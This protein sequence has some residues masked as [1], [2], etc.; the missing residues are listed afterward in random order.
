M[1]CSAVEKH[2]VWSSDNTPN[3]LHTARSALSCPGPF[4][5]ARVAMRRNVSGRISGAPHTLADRAPCLPYIG[6]TSPK[7]V[8][9]ARW[10]HSKRTLLA[11]SWNLQPISEF[12]TCRPRLMKSGG[13]LNIH[14]K[15][16]KRGAKRVLWK[17]SLPLQ[18]GIDC[19]SVPSGESHAANTFT[20]GQTGAGSSTKIKGSL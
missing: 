2:G 4:P 7:R 15:P 14:L 18:C 3:T 13:P 1:L 16:K 6:A 10:R 9:Q 19:P 5:R 17:A 8:N 20:H 11:F 12:Q